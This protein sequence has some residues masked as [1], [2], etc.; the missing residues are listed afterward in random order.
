[1]ICSRC[2][3]QTETEEVIIDWERT[4]YEEYCPKCDRHFSERIVYDYKGKALLKRQGKW[5]DR[6]SPKKHS[7]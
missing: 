6:R 3:S 2:G 1:M 4:H 5:K 7:K